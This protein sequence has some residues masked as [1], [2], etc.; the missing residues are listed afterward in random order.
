MKLEYFIAKNM[1]HK[2][3][4]AIAASR[5]DK[6]F[7]TQNSHVVIEIVIYKISYIPNK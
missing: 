6:C 5:S 1:N 2:A 7:Y 4:V 3:G